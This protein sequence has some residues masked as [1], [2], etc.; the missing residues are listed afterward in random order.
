MLVDEFGDFGT[1][2]MGAVEIWGGWA[3]KCVAVSW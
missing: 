1:E 2:R 3:K